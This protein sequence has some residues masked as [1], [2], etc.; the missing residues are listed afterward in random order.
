[1]DL[2]QYFRKIR[3]V[4]A[5]INTLHIFVTS[6]ETADGGKAGI[7]TEVTRAI[8]AKMIA[9]GRAVLA[10]E[11]EKQRFL[12]DQE[13]ERLAA[14]RADAARR[15]QVTV[16]SDGRALPSNLE[17]VANGSRSLRK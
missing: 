2:R 9:E 10:T 13:N 17:S 16:V 6:L 11:T 4:E 14:E 7:V 8:A 15:V 1:V 12:V 5:T 3:E